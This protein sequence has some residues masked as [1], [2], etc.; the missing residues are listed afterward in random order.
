MND[1]KK[2]DQTVRMR[3]PSLSTVRE[4]LTR[5][6]TQYERRRGITCLSVDPILMH[7]DIQFYR[8]RKSDGTTSLA[9]VFRTGVT[10]DSWIIWNITASQA[11]VLIH[12]FP[13]IYRSINERNRRARRARP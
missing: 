13:E 5:S 6:C 12:N 3:G 9:L 2:C 8:L 1:A 11:E 7:H 4:W 10:V